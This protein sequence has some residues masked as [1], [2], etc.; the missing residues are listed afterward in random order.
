MRSFTFVLLVALLAVPCWVA[1]DGD[2]AKQAAK[3]DNAK[4][5]SSSDSKAT[6]RTKKAAKPNVTITKQQ[7]AAAK[8]LVQQHHN[9]LFELLI[10]LKEGSPNEYSR[11]IRDL[12]RA[13]ERL[14][15][16]EKRDSE[17]YKLELELWK[18]Q[19]RRQL[20]TAKLQMGADDSLLKE[21]RNTL[22]QEQ[23]LSL[24]IL[25]HERQ[26]LSS[27]LDKLDLQLKTQ[28]DGMDSTVEKR[29]AALTRNAKNSQRNVSTK[30]RK[31]P[32]KNKTKDPT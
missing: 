16:I 26:K 2:A 24:A 20:I 15:S 18:A 4:A 17:R 1:A 12:S 14:A 31:A 6:A 9:D 13:S 5:D 3:R 10:H 28:Q 19:S 29:F 25:Q 23:K 7:E 21:L 11:A 27:R 30:G 8:S 32:A 22:R